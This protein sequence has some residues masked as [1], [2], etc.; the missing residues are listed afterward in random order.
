MNKIILFIKL[1]PPLTGVTL[2]NEY[3]A[4]SKLLNKEYQFKI[5]KIS[6]NKKNTGFGERNIKKTFI[7]ISVFFNLVKS[8]IFF[9]PA[10][11]YFQISPVGIAFLRDFIYVLIIKLFRINILFHLHGIGI[12]EYVTKHPFFKPFYRFAFKNNFIICLSDL[13][14]N[15]I[16]GLY[17]SV[18]FIVNN[19]IKPTLLNPSIKNINNDPPVIMFLSNLIRFKGL[20]DFIDALA[21]INNKGIVFT[22]KIIG[23]ESDIRIPELEKMIITTNLKGKVNYLGPKYNDEK[24][25]E[26]QSADI[27]V[28]PT[29][30]DA[31]GLAV[32]EAMEAKLPV[33]AT[34]EG[35]LPLIV[36]DG[37]TGFLVDK[38]NP[39]QIAEKIEMLIN[40]PA[41][42]ESMGESGRMR[43]MEKFT[44]N[45]FEQN[46]L[47]VFK[48][49]FAKIN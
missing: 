46:M 2:L 28:Y 11:I 22:A 16:D 25:G 44:Y 36:K 19:G 31:W 37:I 39:I 35:S 29:R 4:N 8:V 3:I 47:A 10:L 27:F 32:L 24:S 49:V 43:F 23:A 13:V 21:I 48:S 41:L 42:R 15:D 20:E 14:S 18:P 9:R 1:P 17:N 40:N 6:Y 12:K 5:I 45:I 26:L 38:Y 7:I 34:K 30:Y 33:I